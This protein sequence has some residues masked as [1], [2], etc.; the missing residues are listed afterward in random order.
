M[1]AELSSRLTVR[2][3]EEFG[4]TRS[5]AC[6]LALIFILAISPAACGD[7]PPPGPD[8]VAREP[9]S[10]S[11]P[12]IELPIATPSPA[13]R[14]DSVA[15]PCTPPTSPAALRAPSTTDSQDLDLQFR[16][17]AATVCQ[18]LHPLENGHEFAPLSGLVVRNGAGHRVLLLLP[19]VDGRTSVA[20]YRVTLPETTDVELVTWVVLEDTAI[21]NSDGVDFGVAVGDAER[22]TPPIPADFERLTREDALAGW[23]NVRVDLSAYRGRTV[24]VSLASRETGD[25]S[26]D[27]LLWADPRIVVK[28]PEPLHIDLGGDEDPRVRTLS[29]LPWEEVNVFKAY[30]GFHEE[31]EAPVDSDWAKRVLPW[32]RTFRLFSSLGANWGPTLERDHAG[33]MGHNPTRD[34]SKERRWAKHYEF[35]SDGPGWKDTPIRD[36]FDW[37]RFDQLYSRIAANGLRMQINLSGAPELFTGGKGHY[38]TYHF[39]EMPVVDELGWKTYVDAVFH[40][41]SQQSWFDRTRYSFFS[42]ANCRWV[43]DDGS[44]RNFGYQGDAVEHARQYL[45]TWQAMKPYVGS[46]QVHLGPFVVEPDPAVPATD[47]LARYLRLLRERFFDAGEPLPPW[48]AFA[49]NLYETPHLAI[50]HFA[51]YKIDN[52]RRVL[53]AELPGLDLPLRFDEIGIHPILASEFDSTG[54][55]PLEGTRWATAWHAEM[56]ALLVDQNIEV[57]APWIHNEIMRPHASYVFLSLVAGAFDWKLSPTGG[58]SLVDHSSDASEKPLKS[59][60]VRLGS[61][62]ADR[63]GYLWSAP[64]DEV[65]ARLAIWRIPRFPISDTPIEEETSVAPAHVR[66]PGCEN[67][68]CTA[69]VLGYDEPVLK[70]ARESRSTSFAWIADLPKLRGV[71]TPSDGKFE[72]GLRPGD[73]YFVEWSVTDPHS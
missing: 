33:Q 15:A 44:V 6:N 12:L 5:A 70:G 46:D 68:R 27:W 72:I 11:S 50:D 60:H 65:I 24:W 17:R 47:N 19:S 32:L 10:T 31:K 20:A 34:S 41:L 30:S 23:R 64:S 62:N 49:F 45:W 39:N 2:T 16:W 22:D 36:R 69:M 48:S 3:A 4:S 55:G 40:H 67:R 9:L 53:R 52:V 25:R 37:Q 58:L 29:G 42:E 7:A 56:L 59:V 21:A 13:R 61:A 28:H 26:G 54:E 73:V 51:S 38:H 35:F 14:L 71:E 43:A 66:V 57:G 1:T 18:D 8:A 63:I